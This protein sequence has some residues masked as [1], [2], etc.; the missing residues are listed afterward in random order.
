MK[1]LET[2]GA[3]RLALFMPFLQETGK[4]RITIKAINHDKVTNDLNGKIELQIKQMSR[5]KPSAS[6]IE[7]YLLD[8]ING[9]A[10]KD[11]LLSNENEFVTLKA[12][13]ISGNTPYQSAQLSFLIGGLSS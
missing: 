10:I 5:K 4:Y 13:W 8:M 7:T 12:K 2:S 11:V 1:Y 6:T 3:T 9:E